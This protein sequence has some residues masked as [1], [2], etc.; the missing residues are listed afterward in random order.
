[1]PCDRHTTTLVTVFLVASNLSIIC[2]TGE[3]SR[4]IKWQ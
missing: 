4:T 1:M 2:V 3:K